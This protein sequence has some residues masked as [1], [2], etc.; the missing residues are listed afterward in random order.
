MR[1]T[2]CQQRFT[3]AYMLVEC[4]I[5]IA[6]LAV[7]MEIAFSA[8]YRYL[9]NSHELA[10]NAHDILRTVQA[11]ESWRADVRE[12]VA[13]PQIVSADGL[14]AFEIPQSNL[15]VAYLFD[16]GSIW[17]KAGEAPPKEILSGVKVSTIVKDQRDRV[18]SW[19]WEIELR[20]KKKVIHLRPLFTFQ[21]VPTQKLP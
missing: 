9:T 3:A 14:T 4:L 11:G 10:R 5:Y 17:R 21:A 1:I 18:T 12:A 6:V 7:V 13:P 19:R 20:T 16:E 8:F 2:P 15:R